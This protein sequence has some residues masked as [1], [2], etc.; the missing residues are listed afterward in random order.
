[1]IFYFQNMSKF[2]KIVVNSF[3]PNYFII[4][5]SQPSIQNLKKITSMEYNINEYYKNKPYPHNLYPTDLL[6]ANH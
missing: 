5:P 3:F 1:M 4:M 6:R 2:F